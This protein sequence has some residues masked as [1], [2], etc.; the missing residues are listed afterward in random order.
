MVSPQRKFPADTGLAAPA[1]PQSQLHIPPSAPQRPPVSRRWRHSYSWIIVFLVLGFWY[2]GFGWGNSGG[3]I[4]GNRTASVP[5]ADDG[6][7]SG[8]GV[9]ILEVANK[10]DYVGQTFQVRNVSVDHWSG[11][12]AV[13]IGSRHSYLPMLLILSSASPLPPQLAGAS[14][15]GNPGTGQSTDSPSGAAGN[16][17]RLD[18]TGKIVKAPPN[19]QAKQQW[20]LS[21]EDVDQLEEEGVYIQATAV[22][23]AKR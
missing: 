1:P 3:W 4:W 14:G 7:L 18:V 2:V 11:D 20:N 17:Q 5:V 23:L 12:R 6:E 22:Q 19:A 10:Q 16:P 9:A 21:D 13:W 15:T 8:T